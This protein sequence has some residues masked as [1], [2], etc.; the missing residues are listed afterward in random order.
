MSFKACSSSL[1][2]KPRQ[3]TA[4]SAVDLIVSKARPAAVTAAF[5][6]GPVFASSRVFTAAKTLAT[7]GTAPSRMARVLCFSRSQANIFM[8]L[9][10]ISSIRSTMLRVPISKAK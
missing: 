6:S 5:L 10:S 9:A 1:V 2:R 3:L 4:V 8:L 7:S